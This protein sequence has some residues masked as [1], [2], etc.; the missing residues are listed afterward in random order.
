LGKEDYG[1]VQAIVMTIR[2]TK[3]PIV[4]IVN[5]YYE[6]SRRSPA[7]KGLC[8]SIRFSKI[9]KVTVIK[10]LKQVCQ[11]EDITV[12]NETLRTLAEHS[13]G[14]LRSALNDLQSLSMGKKKITE[15]DTTVLGH[16][17]TSVNIF[18]ALQGIFRA[19][20]FKGAKESAYNLDEAP[21]HLLLWIDENLPIEYKKPEDLANAY[22]PLSKASIYLGRVRRRQHY[23]FWSYANDL[24]TAGVA[25]SKTGSYRGYTKY[26]FPQWLTKMSRSR[27]T[28]ALHRSLNTKLSKYCHTSRYVAGVE[29]YP[30]FNYLFNNEEDF[31][32]HQIRDLEL[33]AEEVGYLLGEKTDS[34]IV[35]KEMERSKSKESPEPE[36]DEKESDE[37]R[38]GKGKK[39]PQD[40]PKILKPE[41]EKVHELTQ[42]NLSDF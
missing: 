11:N 33:E 23:R 8:K 20:S 22:I 25:L 41:K 9:P 13:G 29:I 36:D 37:D 32:Y 2:E 19:T 1:G 39:E 38:K 27:G 21:D 17:D 14:D 18:K 28:R 30:Y 35:R 42:K 10:L 3:Q 6:L 31:R 5:D 40:A 4:L 7:I 34:Q 12:S 15:K 24:M 26:Q 16:R